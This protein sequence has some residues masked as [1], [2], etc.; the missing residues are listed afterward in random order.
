MTGLLQVSEVPESR[1]ND[2]PLSNAQ[3]AVPLQPELGENLTDLRKQEMIRGFALCV[4]LM[5]L[6]TERK[7]C[8]RH[9]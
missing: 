4:S 2:E 7:K 9:R 1:Y 8:E 6:K 3:F 5:V